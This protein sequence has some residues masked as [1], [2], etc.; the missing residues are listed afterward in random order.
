MQLRR[1]LVRML[2]AISVASLGVALVAGG[3]TAG[4]STTSQAAAASGVTSNSTW[5]IGNICTCSGEGSSTTQ[6]S[7]GVMN[8]WA[9]WTNA[10]GGIDG[11]RIR[12]LFE[13]DQGTP[14]VGL[15]A[16]QTLANDH[17]IA[18]VGSANNTGS[19][20]ASFIQKAGIPVIGGLGDNGPFGTNSDFYL[21]STSYPADAIVRMKAAKLA[22][23][24]KIATIYCAEASACTAIAGVDKKAAA[25]AGL[26][27]V[28]SAS[29]SATAPSYVSS[30]L[31]LKDSG[32]NAAI[33]AL[34]A[35]TLLTFKT[36][37]AEQG[38]KPILVGGAAE[39]QPFWATNPD[40]EN[41]SG[42]ID[43]FP[44]W[45]TS[46]SAIATYQRVMA[47]YD[48]KNSAANPAIAAFTWGAAMAFETAAKASKLGN[49]PTPK[50]VISGL[51][52]FHDTTLGGL[53]PPLTYKNGN[54]VANCGYGF[55]TKKGQFVLLN[56]GKA[57]CK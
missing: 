3:S 24:K 30:C 50:Q 31:A 27:F 46:V 13:D 18:L 51:N 40:F 43:A 52:T 26:P 29:V 7:E 9:K 55:T 33:L 53:A 35:T 10:N 44:W 17:V 1:S 12:V 36:Q 21:T 4:G 8:A 57:I 22:G 54:R 34:A 19:T 6:A 32:A 41:T 39:I 48:A 14:S 23:A 56:K 38:Y 37:C 49:S 16:A 42:A 5:L 47:K 2:G 45:N 15:A 20:Y 25:A 11:H 28:Y